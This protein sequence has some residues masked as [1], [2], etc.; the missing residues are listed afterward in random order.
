MGGWGVILYVGSFYELR[1]IIGPSTV[2]ALM[3]DYYAVA[4][5]LLT[6]MHN[7]M[8]RIHTTVIA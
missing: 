5:K 1:C 4:H 8:P 2:A 3:L 6:C 7:T